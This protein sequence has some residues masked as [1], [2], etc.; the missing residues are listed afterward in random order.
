MNERIRELA[1][2]SGL[3]GPT[4]RI[5]NSHEATEKFAELI[6]KECGRI[7]NGIENEA[8]L[9]SSVIEEHFGVDR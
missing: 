9:P 3:L 5:G 8:I 6:V 4:S 1:E 2:Q 7:A